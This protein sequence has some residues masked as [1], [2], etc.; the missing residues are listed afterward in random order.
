MDA[1]ILSNESYRVC[2]VCGA[3]FQGE[4]ASE[5]ARIHRNKCTEDNKYINDENAI[6]YISD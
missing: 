4:K 2:K 3:V 5:H 1:T 6:T